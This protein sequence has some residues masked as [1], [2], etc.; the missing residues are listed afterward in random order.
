MKKIIALCSFVFLL[1]SCAGIN[2]KQPDVGN[3]KKI[4]I[5]SVTGSEEYEDIET[6]E[7]QK[8]NL[9]SV[10]GN[11]IKDNVEMINEPQ[12]TVVTHGANALFQVLNGID[13][14]SVIPF[15]TVL[16]N[17]QVKNFFENKDVW[18]KIEDMANRLA[19]RNG[20]RL[21][22]PKGMYELT[23]DAVAPRDIRYVNGERAEAQLLRDIG[24]LCEALD[25]DAIAIA[26]YAFY[27]R[28][29][30]MTS[31]TNNVTPIVDVNVALIDRKGEQVLYT[32]RGWWQQTG[33]ESA[34]I[35]HSYVDLRNDQSIKAYKAAIDQIMSQFRKQAVKKLSAK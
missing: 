19:P 10:I 2:V 4:A 9:L 28:T 14:W 17:E 1:C 8:E 29:G 26:Q 24:K 32:D 15:E 13:G 30:M 23:F 7:G 16:D 21:V 27:Y 11:V 12:V 22:Y 34:K 5:L 20:K 18:G 25:V 33:S 35:R 6:I 31:L 3:V